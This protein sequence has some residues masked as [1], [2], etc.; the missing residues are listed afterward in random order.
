VHKLPSVKQR[1]SK[2]IR[3]LQV[4]A[5]QQVGRKAAQPGHLRPGTGLPRGPRKNLG[6]NRV[7]NP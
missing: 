4:P 1:A 6:R 7:T 2:V 5:A 3:I